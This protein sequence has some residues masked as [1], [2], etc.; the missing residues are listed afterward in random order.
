[1]SSD[2]TR[3]RLEVRLAWWLRPYLARVL[4]VAWLMRCEPDWEKVRLKI[5][6]GIRIRVAR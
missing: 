1:M 5:E 4:M 3:I 6:R 2:K